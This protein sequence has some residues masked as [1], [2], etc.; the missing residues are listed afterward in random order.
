[1]APRNTRTGKLKNIVEFVEGGPRVFGQP[2][3]QSEAP[4]IGSREASTSI[5]SKG[6]VNFEKSRGLVG[7]CINLIFFPVFCVEKPLRY[8]AFYWELLGS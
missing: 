4:L 1:M 6:V 8:G 5:L 3:Q 7:F 2:I